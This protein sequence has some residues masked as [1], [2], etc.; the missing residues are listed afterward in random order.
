MISSSFGVDGRPYA[1]GLSRCIGFG[2][3]R[4]LHGVL[5]EGSVFL[6]RGE[7]LV[8]TNV[9]GRVLENSGRTRAALF[10]GV[11][12]SIG[13]FIRGHTSHLLGFAAASQRQGG[14]GEQ[15]GSQGRSHKEGTGPGISGMFRQMEIGR[16]VHVIITRNTG[17]P[18]DP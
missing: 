14:G 10:R 5:S 17:H 18:K 6:D 11:L 1:L 2:V 8:T 3:S 7:A 13:Y 12:K 16:S 15:Y 9:L 4:H